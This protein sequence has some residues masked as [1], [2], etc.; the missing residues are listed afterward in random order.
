M[1]LN[2]YQSPRLEEPYHEP[3][4]GESGTVVRLLAEIRDAQRESLELQ[5][6]AMRMQKRATAFFSVR[7]II[8]LAMFAVVMFFLV[9]RTFFMPPVPPRVVP[10]AAPPVMPNPAPQ[11]R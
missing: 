3:P 10:R 6:E 11:R 1:E 8:P 4:L 9:S 7:M 2:P 5:R